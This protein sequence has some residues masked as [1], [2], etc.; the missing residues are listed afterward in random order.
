MALSV[1]DLNYASPFLHARSRIFQRIFRLAGLER[2]LV[3]RLYGESTPL[4]VGQIT[5]PEQ[6]L[7][8]RSNSGE[9][10]TSTILA[11]VNAIR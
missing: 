3:P 8:I 7:A 5:W 4:P 10:R 2:G 11:V 9:S 1:Q 6:R